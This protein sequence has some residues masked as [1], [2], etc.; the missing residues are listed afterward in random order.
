LLK[1]GWSCDSAYKEARRIAGRVVEFRR[2]KIIGRGIPVISG[3][4]TFYFTCDANAAMLDATPM[5]LPI[6]GGK[7]MGEV[8][9]M[10]QEEIQRTAD[11]L[12]GE[13]GW[14]NK[15]DEFDGISKS[16]IRSHGI[17]RGD[18]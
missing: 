2:A 9:E 4:A 6:A 15:K 8:Y 11:L 16:R 14:I 10:V 5:G 7:M 1:K 18:F 12:R 17:N 13:S 3:G